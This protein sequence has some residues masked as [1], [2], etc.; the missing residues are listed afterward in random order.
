MANL[1]W[2]KIFFIKSCLH[3]KIR[4][5]QPISFKKFLRLWTQKSVHKTRHKTLYKT[6]DSISFN[7]SEWCK[8]KSPVCRMSSSLFEC[9]GFCAFIAIDFNLSITLIRKTDQFVGGLGVEFLVDWVHLYVDL[10][11]SIPSQ[12]RDVQTIVGGGEDVAVRHTIQ[13]YL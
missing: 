12:S 1:S 7:G 9:V 13:E 4:G 5:N 8:D 6:T 11:Q 2:L 10:I 3:P